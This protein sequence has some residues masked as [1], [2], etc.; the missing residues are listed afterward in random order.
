MTA[1]YA[2]LGLYIDGKWTAGSEGRTEP[3]PG[4]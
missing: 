2:E 3:L 4:V 1:T